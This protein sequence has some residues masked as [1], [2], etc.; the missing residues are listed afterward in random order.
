MMRHLRSPEEWALNEINKKNTYMDSD[1]VEFVEQ[2]Q[3]FALGFWGTVSNQDNKEHPFLALIAWTP[4]GWRFIENL[5]PLWNDDLGMDTGSEEDDLRNYLWFIGEKLSGPM[6]D[7][8]AESGNN[9]MPLTNWQKV[10]KLL[11]TVHIEGGRI[12]F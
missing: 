10:L 8:L 9:P 3:K 4:N 1:V 5:S 11:A 2:D 6:N 12:K 7:Y